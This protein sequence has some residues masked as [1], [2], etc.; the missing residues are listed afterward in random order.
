MGDVVD[1]VELRWACSV[2]VSWADE[3]PAPDDADWRSLQKALRVL[4]E[5]EGVGGPL[6]VAIA[7]ICSEEADPEGARLDG[8]I[9]VL[10]RLMRVGAE[11]RVPVTRSA[12]DAGN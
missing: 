12:V 6:G 7:E 4:R 8:A 11:Q 10:R 2:L 5:S 3:P 9:D 1:L